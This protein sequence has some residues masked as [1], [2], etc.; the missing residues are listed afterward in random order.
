M[1]RLRPDEGFGAEQGLMVF[2]Y[3]SFCNCELR[4]YLP[5]TLE[6]D[7]VGERGVEP[8]E[9]SGH[10]GRCTVCASPVD[11]GEGEGG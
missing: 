3:Y 10:H 5:Q 7:R 1:G 4:K 8:A 11:G 2:W 9:V 6:A